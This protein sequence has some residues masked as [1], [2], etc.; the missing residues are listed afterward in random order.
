MV[1]IKSRAHKSFYTEGSSA[2][3]LN[4]LDQPAVTCHSLVGSEQDEAFHRRLC[5]QYPVERI[6][7][8]QRQSAHRDG[9]LASDWQFKI[10]V[11]EQRLPEYFG[12]H[13][14][15]GPALCELDGD[16]PYARG[17]E[18][19]GVRSIRDR[20]SCPLLKLQRLGNCPKKKVCIQKQIH[21]LPSN[22]SMIS[23]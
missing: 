19:Q 21:S 13:G 10:T 8:K 23:C 18:E 14:E 4:P 20:E 2:D 11:V 16:L 3:R 17:A 15:V 1:K 6:I 9:M 12:I 5:Y 7:V 22:M